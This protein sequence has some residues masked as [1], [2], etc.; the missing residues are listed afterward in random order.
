VAVWRAI[1]ATTLSVLGAMIDLARQKMNVLLVSF[2]FGDVAVSL[3][4]VCLPAILDTD[5][6]ALD[7]HRASVARGMDKFSVP[8]PFAGNLPFD[9]LKGAS[10]S[11]GRPR[12][13][14]HHELDRE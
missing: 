8:T 2:P 3:K 6:P 7:H 11:G 13:H 5:M 9:L 4:R 10:T 12:Q 1:A 14:V